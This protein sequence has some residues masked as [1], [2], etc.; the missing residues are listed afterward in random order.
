MT[1]WIELGELHIFYSEYESAAHCYEEIVL[2]EPS[3]AHAHT[4]LADCYYSMGVT[5]HF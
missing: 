5:F 4:R 3:N 1:T 2:L